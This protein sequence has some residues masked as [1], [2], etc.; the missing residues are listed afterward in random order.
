MFRFETFHDAENLNKT[1]ENVLRLFI[2]MYYLFKTWW[3]L[4]RYNLRQLWLSK[5]VTNVWKVKFFNYNSK[6]CIYILIFVEISGLGA[7]SV[8]RG[9]SLYLDSMFGNQMEA[10]YRTLY[11]FRDMD[12]ISEYFDILAF[13]ISSLVTSKLIL[14]W[15]ERN[16]DSLLNIN[17]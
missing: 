15:Y 3:S 11:E 9:L 7:A 8:A 10:F 12:F 2:D 5:L 6:N 14:R 4:F 13:G 16:F 1:S 17:L